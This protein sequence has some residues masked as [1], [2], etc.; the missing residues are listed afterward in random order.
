MTRPS[1]TRSG[2]CQ[3]CADSPTRGS[4]SQCDRTS[5]VRG[6]SAAVGARTMFGVAVV[7]R[8][9]DVVMG[10]LAWCEAYPFTGAASGCSFGP[11]ITTRLLY[12]AMLLALRGT[13][14]VFG[15]TQCASPALS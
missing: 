12:G 8:H 14:T 1:I 9:R 13:N 7:A 5:G 11:I 3:Q 2:I 10:R 15:G 6:R 4:L